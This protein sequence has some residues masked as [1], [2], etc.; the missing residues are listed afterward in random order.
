MLN[1]KKQLNG[2][3]QFFSF[4]G[5]GGWLWTKKIVLFTYLT[6]SLKLTQS[7]H[8]FMKPVNIYI[9]SQPKCVYFTLQRVVT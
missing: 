8:S 7:K 5:T 2:L 9:K 6:H 3:E 4:F 1:V